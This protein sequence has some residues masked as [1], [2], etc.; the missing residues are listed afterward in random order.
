MQGRVAIACQAHGY[1]VRADNLDAALVYQVA[2]EIAAAQVH[3][4]HAGPCRMDCTGQLEVF[5][6]GQAGRGKALFRQC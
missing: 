1:C 6:A 3:A 5:S 4:C 2:L